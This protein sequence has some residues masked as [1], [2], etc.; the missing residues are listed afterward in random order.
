[1]T[2]KKTSIMS[3]ET[4]MFFTA[5]LILIYFLVA[6][7]STSTF[8]YS[9]HFNV[10]LVTGVFVI[11]AAVSILVTSMLIQ[12]EIADLKSSGASGSTLNTATFLTV[13]GIILALFLLWPIYQL[14]HV[15]CE[16]RAQT[17]TQAKTQTQT[18]TA[19]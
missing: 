19:K 1:M 15:T 9:E 8:K 7:V 11:G 18:Q 2:L 4:S 5:G 3:M 6:F 12:N 14:L 13:I 17:Q 10:S 16:R